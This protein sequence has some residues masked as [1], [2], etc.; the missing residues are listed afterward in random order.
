MG[1][2]L[3]QVQMS[4][5]IMHIG[6][7]SKQQYTKG[8]EVESNAVTQFFFLRKMLDTWYGPVGTWFL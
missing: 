6:E 7:K 2:E 4:R 8:H 1:E 5:W 3:R